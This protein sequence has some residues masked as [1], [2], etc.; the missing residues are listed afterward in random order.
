[1]LRV[2]PYGKIF[3]HHVTDLTLPKVKI[4]VYA[5]L[6]ANIILSFLQSKFLVPTFLRLHLTVTILV[7]AAVSS[8]SLSFFATAVDSVFDPMSNLL[9][10]RLHRLSKKLDTNKWPV[11]GARLENIG[12]VCYGADHWIVASRLSNRSQVSCTYSRSTPSFPLLTSKRMSSVNLVIIVESIRS[13]V[14][15]KGDETNDFFIP[16]IAAVSSALG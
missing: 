1:M 10:W 16:A 13:I 7:Y 8:L 2:F 14:T 11:G 6:T 15:H 5:S 3:L 12:N 9:L 4:A